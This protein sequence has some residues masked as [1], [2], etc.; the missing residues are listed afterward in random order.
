MTNEQT[1]A[2]CVTQFYSVDRLRH[3]LYEGKA[4]LRALR[5]A[6]DFG[7]GTFNEIDGELAMVDGV[8]YR[9]VAQGTTRSVAENDE[10]TP[11]AIISRFEAE[12]THEVTEP[13]SMDALAARLDTLLDKRG[14]MMYGLRIE[15]RFRSIVTRAPVRQ[16][17]PYKGLK[18]LIADQ[19]EVTKEGIDGVL[20]GFFTPEYMD[21]VGLPG[22]HLH[23]LD[24]TRTWGGHAQTCVIES[25]KIAVQA[26]PEFRMVFA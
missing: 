20:L 16:K 2:G 9:S 6:G 8:I 21:G 17:P 5:Q 25:G 7:I 12:S 19:P 11:Y 4:P 18:D 13:L 10:C 23:F 1:T 26:L 3:Q 24:A 22:Y 14:E 15:G